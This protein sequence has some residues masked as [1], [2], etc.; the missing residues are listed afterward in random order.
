MPAPLVANEMILERAHRYQV[1]QADFIDSIVLNK[2]KFSFIISLAALHFIWDLSFV[3]R[4]RTHAHET[5]NCN[6]WTTWEVPK[7]KFEGKKG[8]RKRKK[9]V[10]RREGK[11]RL[12]I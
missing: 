4:D 10:G 3:T 2:T 6:H 9:E 11:L 1:H 5:Q 7:T 8:R 12:V